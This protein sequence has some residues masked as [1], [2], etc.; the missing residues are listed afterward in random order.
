MNNITKQ[1]KASIILSLFN[2]PSPERS[3]L[4]D[5][6]IN[7]FGLLEKDVNLI[8]VN[9]LSEFHNG[10][11]NLNNNQFNNLL[12]IITNK[13]FRIEDVIRKL[14]FY[15]IK[16]EY[17]E[18]II[19]FINCYSVSNKSIDVDKLDA[20]FKGVQ[21]ATF[22]EFN[23]IINQKWTGD[24]V[25]NPKNVNPNRIQIA[26]MNETGSYSRGYYI[27]ADIEKMEPIQYEGKIRYRIFIKDPIIVNS[28]NRNVKF[29]NN[30]VKYIK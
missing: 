24:W 25:I 28:G 29:K 26:S 6:L 17:H 12:T 7:Q 5:S 20:D 4:I 15:E 18:N 9:I 30:P 11:N 14:N 22:D 1:Q 23:K 2:T 21:V 10:I 13:S 27:N 16:N 3:K 19:E 8:K